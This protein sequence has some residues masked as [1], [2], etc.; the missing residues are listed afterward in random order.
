MSPPALNPI[1]NSLPS[2]IF[3]KPTIQNKFACVLATSDE[4]SESINL[5]GRLLML[6]LLNSELSLNNNKNLHNH[7]TF[8]CFP[9]SWPRC[10]C[11]YAIRIR[12]YDLGFDDERIDI[13]RKVI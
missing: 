1:I 10:D 6:G 9:T 3:K 8:K 13:L 5:D 4:Y 2:K 7:S 12:G 11:K